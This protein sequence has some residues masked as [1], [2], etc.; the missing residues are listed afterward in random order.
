MLM[1]TGIYFVFHLLNNIA[2]IEQI[3]QVNDKNM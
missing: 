2:P 3:Q 1:D